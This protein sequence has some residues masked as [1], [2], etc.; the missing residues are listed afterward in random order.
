MPRYLI[1][2]AWTAL[3]EEEMASKGALS[4]RI[5]TENEQ[6]SQVT[7]EHSHVVMDEDGQLKSFCV[8]SSPSTELVREHAALLGDH[9][10]AGIY[11]IG[12]DIS[13]GDF[14]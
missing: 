10:V 11:E 7:W 8:Y 14:D 9:T 2:R 5:L 1:E 12:G 6:F 13:P 4:K 3:E